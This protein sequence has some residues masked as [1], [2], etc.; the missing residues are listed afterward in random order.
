[1]SIRVFAFNLRGRN[2][3]PTNAPSLVYLVL[4]FIAR[5]LSAWPLP[6]P[7][8][9]SA[10]IMKLAQQL[11]AVRYG[12]DGR[13]ARPLAAGRWSPRQ[14]GCECGETQRG[15]SVWGVDRTHTIGSDDRTAS[16]ESELAV[17]M[18]LSPVLGAD[19]SW[20]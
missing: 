3:I 12:K 11:S 13:R 14:V 18:A 15:S 9:L 4:M 1:M 10:H 5:L 6:C 19:G 8:D 7:S 17:S 20:L 2:D 16:R